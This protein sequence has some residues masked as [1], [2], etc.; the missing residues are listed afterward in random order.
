MSNKI[1]L[2]QKIN[3]YN[4]LID[5]LEKKKGLISA[6]FI[7]KLSEKPAETLLTFKFERN[8]DYVRF[9]KKAVDLVNEKEGYNLEF[10][11]NLIVKEFDPYDP[12]EELPLKADMRPY[13][14]REMENRGVQLYASFE[15]LPN[16][17]GYHRDVLNI[18]DSENQKIISSRNGKLTISSDEEKD[19]GSSRN[20]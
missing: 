7:Y 14:F 11:L 17:S 12:N 1:D 3:D 15:E 8:Q 18:I 16:A 10:N 5:L 6:D 4:V 20:E 9:F 19:Q 2:E 13:C